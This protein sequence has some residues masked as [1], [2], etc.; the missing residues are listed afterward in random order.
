[1][2]IKHVLKVRT[3]KIE[4]MKREEAALNDPD[5]ID[6][7]P[8]SLAYINRRSGIDVSIWFF[9]AYV[10]WVAGLF[11]NILCNCGADLNPILWYGNLYWREQILS[12]P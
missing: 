2:G 5:E 12:A 1:M 4:Q 6:N 9:I 8:F 10:G 11:I 7:I 3:D